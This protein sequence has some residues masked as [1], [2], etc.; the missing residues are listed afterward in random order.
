MTYD[1]PFPLGVLI[2]NY[3]ILNGNARLV[4]HRDYLTMYTN[5][6][7]QKVF[8]TLSDSAN[9]INKNSSACLYHHLFV[10]YVKTR[11]ETE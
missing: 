8:R 9:D 3:Y 11:Y 6:F 10:N 7:N 4:E 2:R 1:R 5:C